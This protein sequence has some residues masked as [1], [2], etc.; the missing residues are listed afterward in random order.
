MPADDPGMPGAEVLRLIMQF[1]ATNSVSLFY[2]CDIKTLP[3]FAQ[4]RCFQLG[5]GGF[6][7]WS[8]YDMKGCFY[9]FRLPA[10]WAPLFAFDVSF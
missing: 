8:W 7:M 3:F 1:K 6:L 9:I 5:A 2:P 10:A 4:W